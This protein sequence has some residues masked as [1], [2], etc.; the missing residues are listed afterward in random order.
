MTPLFPTA[1]FGSIAWFQHLARFESAEIEVM[2][3]FPKQTFRNRCVV[4]GP[5]GDLRLT[6]PVVKR[7]GSKTLTKDILISEQLDWRRQQWRTLQSAYGSSPFFEHYERDIHE[8]IFTP[9]ETLIELNN[10]ITHRI[11][12]LFGL[13]I[14]LSTTTDFI[15]VSSSPFDLRFVDFDQPPAALFTSI[16]YQQ[17]YFQSLAFSENKSVLDLLFCQGPLGRTQLGF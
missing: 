1:Y 16:P 4:P 2:D 14:E 5:D 6:V 8:L 13:K 11:F 7:Q 12:A 17:V 3:H 10:R 15:P 9:V